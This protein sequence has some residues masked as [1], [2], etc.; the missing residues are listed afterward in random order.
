MT[1]RKAHGTA[2][3]GGATV[4]WE[5]PPIDETPDPPKGGT[6]NV[7][8]GRDAKGRIKSSETARQM[9]RL[10]HAKPD[11]VRDEVR[12]AP[13]FESY[14]RR[15]QELVRQRVAELHQMFGGVSAGVG[16]ILR[17]WGWG[18]AFGEYLAAKAAETGKPELMAQS[19]QALT[20]ASVELQ[21][22]YETCAKEAAARPKENPHALLEEYFGQPKPQP[23]GGGNDA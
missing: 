4:V 12:C 6:T 7:K 20:R 3:K 13:D 22:A 5:T 17:G 15:R 14:N 19:T 2:R 8:A 11:F 10:R 18:V 16:S 23:K 1:W 9:A 21:K